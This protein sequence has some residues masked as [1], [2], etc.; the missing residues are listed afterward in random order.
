MTPFLLVLVAVLPLAALDSIPPGAIP[1]THELVLE[2]DTEDFPYEFFAHSKLGPG[3]QSIE[4]GVPFR[5]S[6]KYGT[7]IF[8]VPEGERFAPEGT[9]NPDPRWAH[10][11]P[12]VGEIHQAHWA[13]TLREVET[14][15][16]VVGIDG[17][18]LEL[19]VLGEKRRRN[20]ALYL[21]IAVAGLVLFGLI[22]LVRRRRGLA[23]RP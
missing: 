6:S 11:M 23:T 15:V 19:V 21:V 17:Q 3:T 8:A 5:F 1:V 14:R 13:S 18:T 9:N 4:A 22:A 20:L 7:Q 2:W 10:S 16:G 12:P